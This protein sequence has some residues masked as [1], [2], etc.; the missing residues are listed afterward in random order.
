MSVVTS[1]PETARRVGGPAAPRRHPG[2]PVPRRP[3]AARM[4]PVA[5]APRRS[6]DRPSAP[7]D[8]L[9]APV[10]PYP[11]RPAP[12]RAASHVLQ[13]AIVDGLPK[14]AAAGPRTRSSSGQAVPRASALR[15]AIERACPLLKAN[16]AQRRGAEETH[17][18]GTG[19]AASG[20][21]D[22]VDHRRV[23]KHRDGRTRRA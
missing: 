1:I 17:R 3:D 10:G 20:Q 2:R 22:P 18:A 13:R 16:H 5:I 21:P 6:A 23:L 7:L 4:S 11:T 12:G 8:P 19:K 15:P 14:S 9:V